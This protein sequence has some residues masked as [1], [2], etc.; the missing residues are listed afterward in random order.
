MLP[1]L[2]AALPRRKLPSPA[3]TAAKG[4]V[5]PVPADALAAAPVP[6]MLLAEG[7]SAPVGVHSA[8]A[9]TGGAWR[10]LRRDG[11]AR[12]GAGLTEAADTRHTA[13]SLHMCRCMLVACLPLF[14]CTVVFYA[15]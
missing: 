3:A 7:L 10:R 1:K 15:R 4:V 14:V 12:G 6:L 13:R 11:E 2:V 5:V 9:G 8:I